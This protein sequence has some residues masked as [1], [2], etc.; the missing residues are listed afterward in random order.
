M[1]QESIDLFTWTSFPSSLKMHNTAGEERAN[2]H[3]FETVQVTPGDRAKIEAN[4]K[5][6]NAS[7]VIKF[8]EPSGFAQKKAP[9]TGPGSHTP[10]T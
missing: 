10:W 2:G 7:V 5:G 6:E 9:S 3:N 8:A 1:R 4:A